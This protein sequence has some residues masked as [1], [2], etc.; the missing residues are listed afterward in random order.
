MDGASTNTTLSAERSNNKRIAVL[1]SEPDKGV[2]DAF[3]KGLRLAT[4][5]VVAFLNS[6]DT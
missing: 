5:D 6:G 1:V 2:Y 3:N 4:G